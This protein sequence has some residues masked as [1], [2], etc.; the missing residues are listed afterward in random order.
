MKTSKKIIP[1]FILL[2]AWFSN[3][4]TQEPLN[5]NIITYIQTYQEMAIKEMQRAGVPASITLAQGILETEAG[6]SSLVIKSNN[7]FGIKCKST[8]TGEKVYHDDDE[9]GECFRKY[10]AA[11]ESYRD[12]SDYLR[13]QP[14][15]ASLFEI[16]P[17][18]YKAWAAGLKKAGY[19]TNPKYAQILIKYIETYKLD[20]Y[21][22][23]ALGR[24]SPESI[25]G[26]SNMPGLTA[27]KPNDMSGNTIRSKEPQT[28]NST[29]VNSQK[30]I[31]PLSQLKEKPVYPAGEFLL[32]N[33]RV[34]FADQGS[35]LLALA[36]Q[37][38]L[39]LHWLLDFN[40]LPDGTD[41]LNKGQLI[42]LQRKRRHS[43][44]EFHIVEAG[45]SLYEIAQQEALRLES[46]LNY[47]KLEPNM[48]PAKGETLYLQRKAPN[49]P[50]LAGNEPAVPSP[51]KIMNDKVGE[52][53]PVPKT[54]NTLFL[55]H[56]VQ[57]K[58][59]LYSLSK[60]YQVGIE[61]LREWNNLQVEDL[62]TGQELLIYKNR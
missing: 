37:Q 41:I 2:L 51:E 39:N 16:D 12:H 28:E 47:N 60:K 58:E 42:Y 32:N 26:I 48:T 11:E 25:V 15:Y 33:T 20:D 17:L 18:N 6:Q 44:N 55:L 3:A 53:M 4:F 5:Q 19:A 34:I 7:H 8:W 56:K 52:E 13:S 31:M 1:I 27:G 14:R 45:E 50:I 49:R 10:A 29:G 46:L 22:L 59:T 30:P 21:T 54:A 24:K 61:K 23:V 62:K 36:E 38:S 40:D 57:P 9:R 43:H 35:S